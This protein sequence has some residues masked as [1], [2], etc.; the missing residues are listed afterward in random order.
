M[1]AASAC[2][3]ATGSGNTAQRGF[4]RPRDRGM[5]SEMRRCREGSASGRRRRSGAG[6]VLLLAGLLG[7]SGGCANHSSEGESRVAAKAE[8]ARPEQVVQRI[9]PAPEPAATAAKNAAA[10][11][12]ERPVVVKGGSSSAKHLEAELNRLEAELK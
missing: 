10:S 5:W 1:P 11:S 9:E 2:R 6:R 8:P 12:A 7:A 3:T 4:C